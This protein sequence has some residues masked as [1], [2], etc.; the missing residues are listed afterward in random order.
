MP[1]YL[2]NR[3]K[4]DRRR[5]NSQ[6][7]ASA[8]APRPPTRASAGR[9]RPLADFIAAMTYP[10]PPPRQTL[11]A[12]I[13]SSCTHLRTSHTPRSELTSSAITV[14]AVD[15]CKHVAGRYAS[16]SARLALR[17]AAFL[18]SQSHTKRRVRAACARRPSHAAPP[19][20]DVS[21][22]RGCA[23]AHVSSG[24]RV[25]RGKRARTARVIQAGDSPEH[26][27]R[28]A[29]SDKAR[30]TIPR[31]EEALLALF[32]CAVH[33]PPHHCQR[34]AA[35]TLDGSVVATA[36]RADLARLRV[37]AR[38]D[39]CTSHRARRRRARRQRTTPRCAR[40]RP[41]PRGRRD[42][43]SVPL[44]ERR[45]G[46]DVVV[47]NDQPKALAVNRPNAAAGWSKGPLGTAVAKCD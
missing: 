5:Q 1:P 24:A 39:Q 25:P 35:E 23:A 47:L 6:R 27:A 43:T 32:L 9:S 8:P 14:V 31:P 20:R 37:K 42:P 19:G 18:A 46:E 26:S 17:L 40:A 13:H 16:A 29:P 2:D 41:N 22:S 34:L 44:H 36:A 11:P 15:L 3:I 45:F 10:Q 4:L 38:P 33:F 30:S 28:V 21:S 7:D 12:S